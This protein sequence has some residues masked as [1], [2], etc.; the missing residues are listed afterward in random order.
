M[1][2]PT[3]Q[4][5]LSPVPFTHVTLEDRFWA[6]RI[7]VN[8][9][10]TLP[11]EYEQCKDTG[12]IDAFLLDWKP[13]REPE[14][15]YFWDSDVAK[16]VEAAS[17]SLAV[18]PD[19]GLG[20][21]VDEVVGKI[22][23]AQQPDGYLNVYFTVVEPE[24]RWSN[25]ATW[26]ELY[27]AGHL[28]EAGV[29]HFEAT[30]KRTLLDVVCRYADY[31][32]SV[33]GPGKRGGCPGHEE[34][35]LALVKLYRA[36]GQRRY[37]DLS[38]FFI[39]QRGQKPSVFVRELDALRRLPGEAGER[40][41]KEDRSS[42]EW[43]Q[44]HLPVREQRE[45]VGHAVRAMYVY[46]GMADVAAETGDRELWAACELLWDNL[47][48]RRMYVTGGIGSTKQ[49][50][51]FGA[52]YYL[53]NESAYAETCA[54]IGL[55]F[56]SHRML[57]FDGDGR[58]ADV[59][60][61]ALYNGT[62]SGVSLDGERFFYENPLE[63]RGAHHRQEWFGCACCPPNI[64]RLLAS[65]G[66][67]AY[68]EGE[69]D[70]YVH[71]FVEGSARLEVAGQRVTLRQQTRYP[72]D[73]TVRITVEPERPGRFGLNLR[74]PGWC[75]DAALAV[76][77]RTVEVAEITRK[78]YARIDRTWKPGDQVEWVLPMPVERVRAHP[79][80][81]DDG[82]CVALMRGPIVYC[83]EQADNPVPLDRMVLPDDAPLE[84]RFDE[85]LLGGVS[86]IEGEALLVEDGEW[87]S[88]LYRT[89]PAKTKPFGIT[90][91]A[92]YAWDHRKPGEM[93]VWIRAA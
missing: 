28:I 24:R 60:E 48:Q 82:G 43:C 27:C 68:S 13:G 53:P 52:D 7:K 34:I 32:D 42:T 10:R 75:R 51:A 3:V 65:L 85:G 74:I 40:F 17:Y 72:W 84:V 61:R 19:P 73:A 5:K 83:L 23:G 1:A 36:T 86:V 44:D 6:P 9:E 38:R 71:L 33:F 78:G 58:Y 69:T 93:R 90:A 70:V 18:H 92:Y 88:A 45:V 30:G 63:S 12:R 29:A 91:V 80:V 25:L 47:T 57:Q 22:A 62:I 89:T 8:R 79:A 67:Y 15:H 16:W 20:A 21:Q 41:Q 14:P 66:G 64:G 39:D 46:S 37:L 4:R 31:I 54:A 56:W 35:E 87:D 11:H 49:G 2:Q 26:H 50:E 55:V 81:R 76:N 59:M 77:G